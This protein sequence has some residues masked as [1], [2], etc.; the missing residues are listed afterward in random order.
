[1]S[2]MTPYLA[3]NKVS[4]NAYIEVRRDARKALVPQVHIERALLLLQLLDELVDV[5]LDKLL[6]PF[7]SG[8]RERA[9]PEAPPQEVQRSVL[10]ANYHRQLVIE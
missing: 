5:H 4:M 7:H 2:D 1:M 6:E 3:E 9:Q 10:Q 8:G